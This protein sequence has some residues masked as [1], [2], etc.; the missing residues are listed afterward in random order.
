[1]KPWRPVRQAHPDN[2]FSKMVNALIIG[3]ALVIAL[4]AAFWINHP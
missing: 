3:T 4:L 1:M 2:G